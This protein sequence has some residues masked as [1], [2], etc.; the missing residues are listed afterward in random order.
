MRPL[1]RGRGGGADG[2][3]GMGLWLELNHRCGKG[4][5]SP[6]PRTLLPLTMVSAVQLCMDCVRKSKSWCGSVPFT[7]TQRG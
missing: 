2:A 3:Q 7:V 6:L 4:E 1:E 5:G